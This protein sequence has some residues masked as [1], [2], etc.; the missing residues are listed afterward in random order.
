MKRT[1][2]LVVFAAVIVPTTAI[3]TTQGAP[4]VPKRVRR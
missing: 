4:P 1:L 2:I 3:A